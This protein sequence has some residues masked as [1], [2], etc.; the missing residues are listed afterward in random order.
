MKSKPKNP[1]TRFY[2][3][4]DRFENL[5][6]EK[7]DSGAIESLLKNRGCT[8]LECH[9]DHIAIHHTVMHP[10]GYTTQSSSAYPPSS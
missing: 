1:K 7:D 8:N 3:I 6:K 10:R 9:Q 4:D 2:H 5:F